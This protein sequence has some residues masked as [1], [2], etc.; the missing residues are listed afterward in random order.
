M[1][2]ERQHGQGNGHVPGHVLLRIPN[3]G[4]TLRGVVLYPKKVSNSC[5]PFDD[6]Q[7]RSRFDRPVTL[8]L[9]RGEGY[10]G[11]DMVVKNLK[12]L[13][14]HKVANESSKSWIW[15][16][17]VTDSHV[18]CS[19]KEKK[20]SQE[21]ADDVIKSLGIPLGK[22]KECMGDSEADVENLVLMKEQEVQVQM[23]GSSAAISKMKFDTGFDIDM[24]SFDGSDQRFK[25]ILN[26]YREQQLSQIMTTRM[27]IASEEIKEWCFTA[28]DENENSV[29]GS[30]KGTQ[31]PFSPALLTEVFLLSSGDDSIDLSGEEY[32]SMLDRME[33]SIPTLSSTTSSISLVP[34]TPIPVPSP[35][36]SVQAHLEHIDISNLADKL[37][38]LLAPRLT[39]LLE[40]SLAPLLQ[41]VQELSTKLSSFLSSQAIPSS[42]CLDSIVSKPRQGEMPY[43][44]VDVPET[45]EGSSSAPILAV[46]LQSLPSIFGTKYFSSLQVQQSEDL[47][48]AIVPINYCDPSLITL[49]VNSFKAV[50]ADI[51][52]AAAAVTTSLLSEDTEMVSVIED[53]AASK[54]LT[55]YLEESESISASIISISAVS[56][57][58]ISTA[59]APAITPDQ[60]KQQEK[61]I[62]SI[63]DLYDRPQSSDSDQFQTES[64]DSS[65]TIAKKRKARSKA[66]MKVPP[67][68]A[69]DSN[70]IPYYILHECSITEPWM[71]YSKNQIKAIKKKRKL[72][73][74]EKG[75]SQFQPPPPP[76]DSGS[77]SASQAPASKQSSSQSS[78]R[79][80]PRGQYQRGYQ[81]RRGPFPYKLRE[82]VETRTRTA[83]E[84]VNRY[85]PVVQFE[86]PENNPLLWTVRMKELAALDQLKKAREQGKDTSNIT[87]LSEPRKAELE[88][89]SSSKFFDPVDYLKLHPEAVV[90]RSRAQTSLEFQQ[91]NFPQGFS[92]YSNCGH[93]STYTPSS[94]EPLYLNFSG[95]AKDLLQFITSSLKKI[96]DV[97]V[98][99]LAASI[100]L[101]STQ[102]AASSSVPSSKGLGSELSETRTRFTVSDVVLDPIPISEPKAFYPPTIGWAESPMPDLDEII[103]IHALYDNPANT[104]DDDDDEDSDDFE[105]TS[106]KK[107]KAK[108]KALPKAAP[109]PNPSVDTPYYIL[110]NITLTPD[111]PN[112]MRY[113][114][115]E[116]KARK[117]SRRYSPPSKFRRDPHPAAGS[118]GN[119]S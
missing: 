20:Y 72:D 76:L 8:L 19:M 17:Y 77:G 90:L 85:E 16:Y 80:F 42:G 13:C 67:A 68:Q 106:S 86:D 34:V 118:S 47:T 37:Y 4:G 56:A 112:R 79:Y 18:R 96:I 43:E 45:A 36:T 23:A 50:D 71:Q 73:R 110:H 111:S 24:N 99:P 3:Y 104:S 94:P 15:W 40:T 28:T 91:T 62:K 26:L 100:S 75:S 33:P 41:H 116:M 32:S 119:V 98:A 83:S 29:I 39:S 51:L 49:Y 70:D 87:T 52:S 95:I 58:I 88:R 101:F 103:Q 89:Y 25:D 11:K 35:P 97:V 21:C 10:E 113:S 59:T 107:R 105:D 44:V 63:D 115:N 57:P 46:D 53:T 81:S 22:I 92:I 66:M 31:V 64:D 93:Q 65:N 12:L 117:N 102:F 69:K 84:I 38:V 114:N 2:F 14:V 27:K 9:D 30:I 54:E 61:Y 108:K 78:Q 55:T 48:K 7:F 60:I 5:S 1:I 82:K 109:K 74:Y 6:P